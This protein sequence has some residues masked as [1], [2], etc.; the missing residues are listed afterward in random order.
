M[1]ETSPQSTP[2]TQT[3]LPAIPLVSPFSRPAESIIRVFEKKETPN[4][5][6]KITV[7]RF[8]SEIASWYE[9]LRNAMDYRDEEV[10]LRASI[11]RILKR[12]IGMKGTGKTVADALLRE[13][14]W[15]HYF[16]NGE[17]PESNIEKVA[18]II[19]LYLRWRKGVKSRYIMRDHVLNEWM[20]QLMSSHLARFLRPQVKKNTMAS[21]M[22]YVMKD[23]VKI[24]DDSEERRNIQ[25]F[26][27]VRR[28]YTKDDVAFLRFALFEQ[29]FGRL[30]DAN[31]EH[32][33]HGFKK[34][35]QEIKSQ[36]SYKLKEK[37]Y[38][39]VK[40][41]APVFIVLEDVL[42]L[43]KGKIQET[44]QNEEDFKKIVFDACEKR[45]KSISAKVR[46][47]IVKS[48]VFLLVTKAIF[49]LS[50]E[51]SYD[52]LVYGTVQWGA[53]GLNIGIPPILLVI[54]SLF[55]TQP[56]EDNSQRI[57]DKIHTVLIEEEP[58][59]THTFVVA[60]K[61]KKTPLHYVFTGLWMFAFFLSFGTMVDI[62]TRMHMNPVS[63][64]VFLFFIAV[65]SFLSY[66]INST[67]HQYMV[68]PKPGMFT[69]FID[70]LFIPIVRVG[71]W[72]TDG[73]SSINV[74]V[75]LFDY[76][77]EIPFKGIFGFFDQLF[78]YLHTKREELE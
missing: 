34:G 49:A 13:L 24:S 59:I 26:L 76:V 55:I 31:M 61:T 66:G 56:K 17:I 16:P 21:F 62:L 40:K 2:D 71:R 7:N 54:V 57:L 68:D 1:E 38:Q 70:F 12:R 53:I 39:Y 11:E 47:A 6:S 14:V 45:Y 30:T 77:I 75:F 69:P 32:A 78:W 51:G 23:S 50:I 10:V 20:Y 65:V 64:V 25:I 60:N 44:F 22:Y 9:K 72:F 5:E 37:I 15:A 63:Q 35:Y 73:I 18:H 27:A 29:I 46:L 4:H 43:K 3:P 42:S 52:Q 41:Q 67:A 74:I 33:V 28:A 58:K 8:V 48:V 36:L 19:D